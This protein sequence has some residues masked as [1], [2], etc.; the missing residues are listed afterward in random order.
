MNDTMQQQRIVV[1]VSGSRA[2]Q[3]ALAWGAAEAR[4]RV[5]PRA[6]SAGLPGLCGLPA[7]DH[8]RGRSNSRSEAIALHGGKPAMIMAAGIG[9]PE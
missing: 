6:G 1:G 7:G 2:S 9:R 4:L 3:A 8:Q 5:V